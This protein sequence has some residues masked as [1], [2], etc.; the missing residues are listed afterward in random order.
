MV[1]H[2][3]EFYETQVDAEEQLTIAL[4]NVALADEGSEQ[5]NNQQLQ[6]AQQRGVQ[7]ADASVNGGA[8]QPHSRSRY[9]HRARGDGGSSDT[10]P[11]VGSRFGRFRVPSP[12]SARHTPGRR[13]GQ[14][15][16]NDRNL[17]RIARRL[18]A[19]QSRAQQR[20]RGGGD[21]GNDDGDEFGEEVDPY[22]FMTGPRPEHKPTAFT[23]LLGSSEDL[24]QWDAFNSLPSQTQSKVL[25]NPRSRRRTNKSCVPAVHRH[26]EQR[27][28]KVDRR[29]RLAIKNNRQPSA[30]VA[31]LEEF[32]LAVVRQPACVPLPQHVSLYAERGGDTAFIL[33]ADAYQRMILHGVCQFHGL[34]S[35]TTPRGRQRGVRVSIPQLHQQKQVS[36]LSLTAYV[37]YLHGEEDSNSHSPPAATTM[38]TTDTMDS[39]QPVHALREHMQQL[40]V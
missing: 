14:R 4:L 32:V 33:G 1:V 17:H 27:Y 11:R 25:T 16:R 39:H 8:R 23:Q 21:V 26:N 34:T 18:A 12:A 22:A 10:A 9:R 7:A 24:K 36:S 3:R 28:L 38:K 5:P 30:A 15:D 31:E 2:D 6:Q 20:G 29:I 37:R 35:R 19:Q 13:R 40:T